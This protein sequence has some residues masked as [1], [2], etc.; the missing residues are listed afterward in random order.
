MEKGKEAKNR[1]STSELAL[2]DATVGD[3]EIRGIIRRIRSNAAAL[4]GAFALSALPIHPVSAS[5]PTYSKVHRS[6]TPDRQRPPDHFSNVSDSSKSPPKL[7]IPGLSSAEAAGLESAVRDS[8]PLRLKFKRS[9][10]ES[11]TTSHETRSTNTA[12]QDPS[13]GTTRHRISTRQKSGASTSKPKSESSTPIQMMTTR[14]SG[15][16]N[17][18]I[19]ITPAAVL[20]VMAWIFRQT[21]ESGKKYKLTVKKSDGTEVDINCEM[22]GVSEEELNSSVSETCSKILGMT[23]TDPLWSQYRQVEGC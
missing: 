9:Y 17:L 21:R 12:S 3:Q 16:I 22:E 20:I 23:Q 19:V 14:K 5:P 4:V 15:T 8:N 7:T 13:K 11:T 2:V 18:E 6:Q 10:N 1:T